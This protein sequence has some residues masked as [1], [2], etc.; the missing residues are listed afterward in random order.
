MN[1]FLV[2]LFFL[3][4]YN[5]FISHQ[6]FSEGSMRC[7]PLWQGRPLAL[8][9]WHHIFYPIGVYLWNRLISLL[10]IIP[11]N[12]IDFIINTARMNA[13]AA[14]IALALFFAIV[15]RFTE[16]NSVAFIA[17]LIL[18]WSNAF[19]FNATNNN[20]PM[21]GFLFSLLA[22]FFIMKSGERQGIV[23]FSLSAI[24]LS[25]AYLFYQSMVL[26]LPAILLYIVLFFRLDSSLKNI[27]FCISYI[28]LAIASSFIAVSLVALLP[29]DISSILSARW[30]GLIKLWTFFAPR[31]TAKF[32]LGL[33]V[34]GL[35]GVQGWREAFYQIFSEGT[36]G[37]PLVIGAVL[38][39]PVAGTL[40]FM[41]FVFLKYLRKAQASYRRSFYIAAAA[42][43]S[44]GGILLVHDPSY[45]KL[46]IQPMAFLIIVGI[47]ALKLYKEFN[48]KKGSILKAWFLCL[49]VSLIMYNTKTVLIPNRFG[50]VKYIKEAGEVNNIVKEQDMVIGTWDALGSLLGNLYGRKNMFIIEDEIIVD[51][52]DKDLFF[53]NL[54]GR[55]ER[56]KRHGGK[57]YFL[58]VLEVHRARWEPFLHKIVGLSYDSFDPY[59][60]AS[61]L[62][63]RYSFEGFDRDIALY[64]YE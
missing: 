11:A 45:D 59:R 20:E 38:T 49:A 41:A 4:I 36:V 31:K 26:I 34:S 63:K 43:L 51:D 9:S 50:E 5:A 44:S 25:L 48:P 56:T 8:H 53:R 13:F 3:S 24:S 19:L 7:L 2:F 6:V 52:L 21:P 47:L 64:E 57:V 10:N 40:A 1:S 61:H 22:F 30:F 58:G 23:Y 14:S 33:T 17:V 32:L 16:K 54:E 46:W 12:A 60:R 35:Y 15:K 42:M 62:I 28:F 37:K 55:M 27:S 18:G 29:A 39:V